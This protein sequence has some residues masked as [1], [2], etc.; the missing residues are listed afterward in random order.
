M[1]CPT[2]AKVNES[3]ALACSLCGSP[4]G[5]AASGQ[6]RRAPEPDKSDR[7]RTAPGVRTSP[8]VPAP[9]ANAPPAEPAANARK[10]PTLQGVNAPALQARNKTRTVIGVAMPG[11]GNDRPVTPAPA[12][13]PSYERPAPAAP[14]LPR[15]LTPD[16]LPASPRQVLSELLRR[17]GEEIMTD[18]RRC[19]SLL[20][21]DYHRQ[22]SYLVAALEE[23]I[24]QRLVV[25]ST[26]APVEAVVRAMADELGRR[27]ELPATSALYAV[28]S[29]AIALGLLA[30]RAGAHAAGV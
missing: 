30:P 19:G 4:L 6:A 26:M 14:A 28:E 29:W 23:R 9:A 5:P 16:S 24:P 12:P 25:E 7:R 8:G 11:P 18:P 27:R 13:G 15:A 2:C 1:L 20:A 17:H 21:A 10:V 3:S 22:V